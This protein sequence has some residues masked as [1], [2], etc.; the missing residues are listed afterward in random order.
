MHDLDAARAAYEAS[1]EK[2]PAKLLYLCRGGRNPTT[3]RS[4]WGAVHRFNILVPGPRHIS[5]RAGNRRKTLFDR[6]C[7]SV[8][9]PAR[10]KRSGT[11]G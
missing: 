2:Y 4:M 3:E 10:H 9:T 8:V 7:C 1:R 6:L 5:E 11:S